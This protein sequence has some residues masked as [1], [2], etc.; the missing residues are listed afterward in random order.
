MQSCEVLFHGEKTG[1]LAQSTSQP[2][3]LKQ[4]STSQ[5]TGCASE[6]VRITSQVVKSASQVAGCAS[7]VVR[8]TSQVAA[9]VLQV[10]KSYGSHGV[11]SSGVS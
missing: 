7:E 8:I 3:V 10:R 11:K 2:H 9:T 6:V 4:K 5:V 1:F